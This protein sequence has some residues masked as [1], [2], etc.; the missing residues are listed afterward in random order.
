MSHAATPAPARTPKAKT[1]TPA[2]TR[3]AV[4]DAKVLYDARTSSAMGLAKKPPPGPS[5]IRSMI[6]A[7]GPSNGLRASRDLLRSRRL[8]RPPRPGVATAGLRWPSLAFRRS[9]LVALDVADLEETEDGLEIT[10]RPSKMDQQG[11]H[12]RRAANSPDRQGERDGAAG[13]AVMATP[14]DENEQKR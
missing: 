14:A 3:T 11:R 4:R 7:A 6:R 1:A 9:E 12:Y 13:G 8:K 10:I 2:I 5:E